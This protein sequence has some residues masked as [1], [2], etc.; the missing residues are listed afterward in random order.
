[1]RVLN[2]FG[3]TGGSTLA[4]AAAGAEVVH[5][6]AARNIVAW[7]RRN[8]TLSRLADAPIRWIV[9][10]AM[11]F[12]KRELKRGNCYDAVILDPPSYGHGPRGEVWRLS[13]HLPRLLAL[14]GELIAS[15]PQFILLTCHTPGYDAEQLTAMVKEHCFPVPMGCIT[16]K[17]LF[18][19]AAD[20]RQ[21]PSGVVVRW[22]R[23]SSMDESLEGD[24]K[25]Q[26]TG[27]DPQS[28]NPSP[29]PLS[30]FPITSPQNPRVKEAARLRDRRHREK[31]GRILIDGARELRRAIGAG[32]RLVELYVCEPLCQS[33]DAR[34]LLAAL[35]ITGCEVLHVSSPVFEK[36][37]FGQRAEGLL[38]VAEMPRPKLE[39]FAVDWGG[40]S[41]ATPTAAVTPTPPLVVV[42]EAVEKPGNLG[43]VLRSADAAGVSA[44]IV[45]YL[46]TD[47]Y[48]P[49]AIRASLGTIFT[50]PVCAATGADVL[51]WLRG[52]NL[53]VVAARVDVP[54]LTPRSIIA[55]RR[56]LCSAARPR[57]YRRCGPPATS[58]PYA[59]RCSA[60]PTA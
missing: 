51:A 5:V 50:M 52:H 4:A 2:L 55:V 39:S 31:Q 23:E 34:G 3:Y 56:P 40:S 42:L 35:P 30:V 9:E 19:R 32:V 41:A 8:A 20:G 22:E 21:L 12:V 48:N 7:A 24:A 59:C 15:R 11:K 36:L 14:C 49:N 10:D 53:R 46:R 44:V 57:A 1:M 47:L 43:A 29:E 6:D 28:L 27:P 16:A 37:A 45:A 13:K 60:R 38:G 17:S 58:R 33:D 26:A 25:P 54:C 18:I